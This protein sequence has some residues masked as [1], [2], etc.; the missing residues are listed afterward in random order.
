MNKLSLRK[1]SRN[2]QSRN[3]TERAEITANK[4]KSTCLLV[5]LMVTEHVAVKLPWLTVKQRIDF[6]RPTNFNR[7]Q[8]G[9][10]LKLSSV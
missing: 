5:F 8:D 6:S 1:A 4:P 7:I 9:A 10:W 2:F 3:P